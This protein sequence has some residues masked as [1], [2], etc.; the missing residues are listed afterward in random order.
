MSTEHETYLGVIKMQ[1]EKDRLADLEKPI[2]DVRS[3]AAIVTQVTQHEGGIEAGDVTITAQS[4]D[5]LLFAHYHLQEL[6]DRLCT[7]YHQDGEAA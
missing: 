6:V 5:T 1:T 4:W 2:E 7:Q 3:M